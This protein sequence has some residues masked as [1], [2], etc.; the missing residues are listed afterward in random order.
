MKN[1]LNVMLFLLCGT[2]TCTDCAALPPVKSAGELTKEIKALKKEI[3]TFQARLQQQREA[4]VNDVA[5]L[6][7]QLNQQGT[8]LDG[9]ADLGDQIQ[10][11]SKTIEDNVNSLADLKLRVDALEKVSLSE[12][13]TGMSIFD[14]YARIDAAVNCF[15]IGGKE[16]ICKSLEEIKTLKLDGIDILYHRLYA[17]GML[18]AFDKF[19]TN[20][21]WFLTGSHE[22]LMN[23]FLGKMAGIAVYED[24]NEHIVSVSFRDLL[25]RVYKLSNNEVS[26]DE[27]YESGCNLGYNDNKDLDE[28]MDE[29]MYRIQRLELEDLSGIID[30]FKINEEDFEQLTKWNTEISNIT[31]VDNDDI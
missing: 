31:N 9:V 22:G 16:A 26:A 19:S 18:S 14:I 30:Q 3:S 24:G 15:N 21:D 20:K 10:D 8:K 28:S 2:L 7:D 23:A 1:R 5:N 6:R 11:Q 25:S 27:L 4:F 29:K 17:T 12:S 13:V